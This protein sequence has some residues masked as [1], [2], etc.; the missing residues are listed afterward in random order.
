[1][2]KLKNNYRNVNNRVPHP[3]GPWAA[4]RP[5]LTRAIL[6]QIGACS[7]SAQS[8][9]ATRCTCDLHFT[10]SMPGGNPSRLANAAARIALRLDEMPFREW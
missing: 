9:A 1:M 6:A 3:D 7:T 2:L 4:T 10:S 8:I 5:W